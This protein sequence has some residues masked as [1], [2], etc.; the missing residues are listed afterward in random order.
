M[1]LSRKKALVIGCG[2]ETDHVERLA[3]DMEHVYYFTPCQERSPKF[4]KFATGMGIADNMEKVKGFMTYVDE[5]D[6]I[7]F[8]DIGF[9][10]HARYLKAHGYPVFGGTAED[11]E[12]DRYFLK[13][14]QEAAHLPVQKYEYIE[15]FEKLKAH[16]KAHKNQV[17][18]NTFRGTRETFTAK[19]LESVEQLLEE[20]KFG[21]GPLHDMAEFICEEVLEG[22]EAGY[23]GFHGKSWIY[24][25]L[26]G[27]SPTE[28]YLGK[29]CSK[30]EVPA[31]LK[32]VIDKLDK[33][34]QRCDLSG[35]F[36]TEIFIC[37]DKQ[38]YLTDVTT[39]YAF[40]LSLI[41]TAAMEN[42]SEFVYGLA[43]GEDIPPKFKGKYVGSVTVNCAHTEKNW[44]RIF[45]PD[46]LREQIRLMDCVQDQKGHYSSVWHGYVDPVC[47]VSWGESYAEVVEDLKGL[48]GEVS[49][50]E[51]TSAA[52]DL[53]ACL[54]AIEEGKKVGVSI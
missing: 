37:K 40:P 7:C 34:L 25:T 49:G 22:T 8:M 13:R 47:I 21:Y 15:G 2:L 16:L 14:V 20:I 35:P 5:V 18:K 44:T 41:Y 52:S 4:E 46:E 42:Y 11:L 50:D 30:E 9:G 31:I 32:Q 23:D 3:R 48:Q 26:V 24:P 38:P 17:V 10:D 53:D 36:S 1:D 54:E 6:L 27:F 33:I 51:M 39:R 29:V 28:A 12:E 19:N 45:F 43:H